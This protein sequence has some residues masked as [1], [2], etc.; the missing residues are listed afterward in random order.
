MIGV[1]FILSS[2]K[3]SCSDPYQRYLCLCSY[4]IDVILIV[5]K[6]RGMEEE[7]NKNIEIDL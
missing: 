6:T 2:L 1:F 3:I 5:T 7:T 4:Q